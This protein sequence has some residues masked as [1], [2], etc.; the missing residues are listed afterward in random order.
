MPDVQVQ[1]IAIGIDEGDAENSGRCHHELARTLPRLSPGAGLGYQ[2]G[3]FEVRAGL[4]MGLYYNRI[5]VAAW[6]PSGA[7]A[8][9][10]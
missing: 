8:F 1:L 5:W 7:V 6:E 10:F 9:S 2:L 3:R 4:S